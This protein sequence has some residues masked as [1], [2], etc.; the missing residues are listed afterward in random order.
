MGSRYECASTFP[1]SSASLAF[2]ETQNCFLNPLGNLCVQLP[3]ST[4]GAKVFCI[5][6]QIFKWEKKPH[7]FPSTPKQFLSLSK[8]PYVRSSWVTVGTLIFQ[9]GASNQE[10]CKPFTIHHSFI[11]NKEQAESKV[12]CICFLPPFFEFLSFPFIFLAR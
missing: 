2:V 12:K 8:P 6:N 5:L 11:I 4:V 3:S 10:N 1:V 7:I 9:E